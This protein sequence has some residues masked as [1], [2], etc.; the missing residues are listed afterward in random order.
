MGLDCN[1]L[2]VE[3]L[4]Q[5]KKYVEAQEI[6]RTTVD[7][8]RQNLKRGPDHAITL[9]CTAFYALIL[10][11]LR[12]TEQANALA[13]ENIE[14][15][16]AIYTKAEKIEAMG[17]RRLSHPERFALQ[18]VRNL[19]MIVFSEKSTPKR[20]PS[21]ESLSTQGPGSEQSSRCASKLSTQAPG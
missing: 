3:C 21:I 18:E 2:Q 16:E 20:T 11:A 4:Y 6:A 10:K 8:M 13:R 12:R 7:G 5:K 9:R 19:T 1:C 17:S 15:L 14:A